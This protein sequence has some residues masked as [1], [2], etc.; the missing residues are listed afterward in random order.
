MIDDNRLR[1]PIVM[2]MQALD[3][4]ALTNN[5]EYLYLRYARDGLQQSVFVLA[6]ILVPD[7][8]QWLLLQRVRHD[9]EADFRTELLHVPVAEQAVGT[10]ASPNSR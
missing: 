5:F 3:K 1:D 9:S 10:S 4:T 6:L 7:A 8:A 2:L